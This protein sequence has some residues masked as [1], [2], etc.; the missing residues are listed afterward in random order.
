MKKTI[1]HVFD[2][3]IIRSYDIRGVYKKT[4]FLDDAKIIG[5]V[6]G[7]EMDEGSTVNVAYDGRKSSKPLGKSMFCGIDKN[8]SKNLIKPMEF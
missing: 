8:I 3:T 1:S 5:N 4:L 6:F 7:L 2:E